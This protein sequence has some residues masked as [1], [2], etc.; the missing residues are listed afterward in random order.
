QTQ[1][2]IRSRC[3]ASL[4]TQI[5]GS[6]PSCTA[7]S[8]PAISAT[9]STSCR[10][11]APR[12]CCPR[13]APPKKRLRLVRRWSGRCRPPKAKPDRLRAADEDCGR[14]LGFVV[15]AD[16]P[17]NGH[18]PG[19]RIP[20]STQLNRK[21]YARSLINRRVAPLLGGRARLG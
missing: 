14:D 18:L 11:P 3:S 19:P 2:S 20:T 21:V 1:A 13:S 7:T 8:C 12:I 6:P 15:R 17:P 5:R 16:V 9:R 10:S 4:D